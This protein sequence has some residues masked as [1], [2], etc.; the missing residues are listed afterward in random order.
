M[1]KMKP[2]NI[3]YLVIHCSATKSTQDY[4]L[5]QLERDHRQRGFERGGYHYYIRRDGGIYIMRKHSE[6]GAHCQGVNRS[7]LGICY[8]G[9]LDSFGNPCD[10]RSEEQKRSLMHLLCLLRHYYPKTL[11]VGH[12][13]L[14]PDR[15]EDGRVTSNEWLKTCPSFDVRDNYDDLKRITQ[16]I[17]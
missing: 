7:S 2:E 10:T 14:S 4:S 9:G 6:V 16:E 11:I 5:E 17:L 8:E 3:R 13:D 12:R 15:N 1:E